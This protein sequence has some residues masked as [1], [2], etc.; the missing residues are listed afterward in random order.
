MDWCD[1]QFLES[2]ALGDKDAREQCYHFLAPQLYTAIVKICQSH[3]V[4]QDLLHDTFIIIFENIHSYREQGLFVAWAKRIAFN[5][6][7][8]FFRTMKKKANYCDDEVVEQVLELN[9]EKSIDDLKVIDELFSVCGYEERAV[10]WLY[11]VEQYSHKEIAELTN[12]SPSYSKSI[13]SRGLKKIRIVSQEKSNA[14]VK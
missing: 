12:K 13:V 5:T 14:R 8:S 1:E 9:I 11:I 7:I 6:T 10:I 4:A 2:L 3:E